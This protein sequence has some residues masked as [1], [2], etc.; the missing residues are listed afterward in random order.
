VADGDEHPVPRNPDGWFA[1]AYPHEI[2]RLQVKTVTCLGRDIV[3]FRGAEGALHAVDPH[4]P[5]LGTH[6]GHGGTVDGDRIRCPFHRWAFDGGGRCVDVPYCRKIPPAARLGTHALEEKNGVVLV[7]FDRAGRAPSFG[8]PDFDAPEWSPPR[9]L[10][11]EYPLHIQEIAENGIDIAHFGPIHG[12]GRASV[13]LLEAEAMPFRYLLRTAYP[14]D[15]IGLPGKTVAVTTEWSYWGLGVFVGVSTAD[16][17]GTRVRHV[18]HFTPV[19]QDRVRF[20]CA[21]AVD[22][23]TVPA[24]MVELVQQKNAELTLRNL[25]E[26]APIW[27]HKIYRLRPTLCDADGPYGILRRWTRRF[28]GGLRAAP[29][30]ADDIGG[31]G[32]FSEI[33]GTGAPAGPAPLA[34]AAVDADAVAH[35]FFTAMRQSFRAEAVA[36]RDFV[37]EYRITGEHGGD[38][39]VAIEGGRYAVSRGRHEAPAVRVRIGAEDWL[40]MN[41]GA[42]DRAAAFLSGKLAVEGDFELAVKLGEAFPLPGENP[43]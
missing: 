17:Y 11:A 34:P 43:S 21:I 2:A 29:A 14:G 12:S 22:T 20:R 25:D 23:T 42:L 39:V 31:G 5:H 15:G 36:G 4:C 19:P 18:F 30:W 28:Y 33:G 40:S 38:Y 13:E 16:D 8:V 35:T 37:V 10:D 9:W 27:A 24:G 26:D 1:V 6:L 7:H 32:R 41:A 3:L